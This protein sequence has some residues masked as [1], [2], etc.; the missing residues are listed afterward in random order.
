MQQLCDKANRWHLVKQNRLNQEAQ[1]YRV[2]SGWH[3][4]LTMTT[5]Q[6]DDFYVRC[7][8][9]RSLSVREMG[10]GCRAFDD[11]FCVFLANGR[12]E[13]PVDESWNFLSIHWWEPV[14]PLLARAVA[15]ELFK[16]LNSKKLT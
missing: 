15:G 8:H 4:S 6:R 3:V 16:R 13:E 9:P 14:P 11:S 10:L 1:L 12:L 5:T 7:L 2:Q